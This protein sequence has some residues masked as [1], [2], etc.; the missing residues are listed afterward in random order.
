MKAVKALTKTFEAPRRSVKIKILSNF[1]SLSGIEA[2]RVNKSSK[3]K[4]IYNEIM[5]VK[6][7]ISLK[8]RHL[9]TKINNTQSAKYE[10]KS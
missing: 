10:Q 4:Q 5:S 7:H 9:K 2:G 6:V 1:F 3:K 8:L